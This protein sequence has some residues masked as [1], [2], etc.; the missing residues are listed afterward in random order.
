MNADTSSLYAGNAA[1]VEALYET[2]LLDPHAVDG[3]WRQYFDTLRAGQAGPEVPHAPIQAAFVAQGRAVGVRGDRES[4]RPNFGSL[5]DAYR[6]DGHQVA[7]ISPLSLRQAVA[8]PE[9]AL[10]HHGLSE[11][12]LAQAV[13][14]SRSR[15]LGTTAKE[16]VANARRIYCGSVGYE[17]MYLPRVEREWLRERIERSGGRA[18]LTSG[19]QR[20]IYEK[21]V[22][23]EGLERYLHQRYV[24]QKRFSLEGGDTLIPVLDH[25]IDRAGVQGVQEIV[26]GMAH[27][28][29]LNV[30]I[31]VMGKLSGELFEE[32]EGRKVYR[33]ELA[34]D[35]KYHLG[36]SSDVETAGGP[37]HLS[38][39][40]NPSH[41]ELINPVVEG[42]VRARQDRRED[43][44]R[45]K[46]LPVLIHG[47][48]AV[49]G[50]G[51]VA[52]TL[53]LSQLRGY[54]TGGSI[55]IVINNQVGF[56]ISDPQD[57]RSSRYCTDVAKMVE[58]P[59]FHVN[60]DD[61]E[62]AIFVTELALAYR[63][64][65][66]KDVFVDLV[67]FRRHGHNESDEPRATQPGMYRQI[68]AHPGV[69][70][71]YGEQLQALGVMTPAD[72]SAIASAYRDALD[73]GKAVAAAKETVGRT[74]KGADWEPFLSL[75]WRPPAHS[76]VS[77]ARLQELGRALTSLPDDLVLHSRVASVIKARREMVV[78]GASVDWG[79]AENLAYASLLTTGFPVRISGQDSGRGTFFHRHAVLHDQRENEL[80]EGRCYVPLRHLAEGQARFEVIDSALSEE[81]VLGFEYG[82]TS[83]EPNA[84]VIWEAQYGDFANGAQAVIDQFISAGE[85][86]WR[87]LSA[88]VMMLPHGYEGQG[89]EHSSARLERFLQLC[90][91]QNMQV[92]VPSTPAQ[93]FHLLRRQLLRP[94]RKPLVI[95]SPKS[96]LRHRLSVSTLEDLAS[97]GFDEL[98]PESRAS[99]GMTRVVLCSGKLYYDL[100]E[101]RDKHG[102]AN[103][104]LV[105]LE[106][107]YP[108]PTSALARELARFPKAEVIWAQEEPHNQ[109]AWLLIQEDL[110]ACL[111]GGQTLL[112]ATRP[113]AA[114]P[115]V[116]Y[117]SKHAAQQQ[118]V[119]QGAL[120]L[121]PAVAATAVS[122]AA[123]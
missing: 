60:G 89:P 106:Q 52:E 43:T 87:R 69:C 18:V 102:L 82:Y 111:G 57:A 118:A 29:R 100:H 71:R 37:V 12:D 120:G 58:A 32:F 93:M 23:A 113:R 92:C 39:G 115:A 41:L 59:V 116:G 50:Q 123:T 104:A 68:D 91:E 88:L 62:A 38:L 80:P 121:V 85:S 45:V 40:F 98:I 10:G 99:D 70:A 24:G 63:Q 54:A 96:M 84:L 66:H 22:A 36:F 72:V 117:A 17:Y 65:F 97:G 7:Q 119:L 94:A 95:M 49:I 4:V 77:V 42:S 114:S 35:V 79:F 73:A 110:R 67:C 20:R 46:V 61:P 101:A 8:V 107:L 5:F 105:R 109:G 30:L 75:D 14:D 26:M 34:G 55:H 13:V 1:F 3:V 9:L 11:R 48:A 122:A 81:A 53:N 78:G 108:F 74:N 2:Y 28:G 47:D 56:S 33:E 21:L 90:A 31:N 76:A 44:Q 64:T 25:L 83:N 51:V 112:P 103:V 16:A 15:D 86:K 19:Q 27:R 6:S